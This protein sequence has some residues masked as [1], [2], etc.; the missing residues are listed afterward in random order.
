M[1]EKPK[2]YVFGRPTKYDKSMCETVISKMAEGCCIAEVCA[3]LGI[4]KDTFHEWV[5][6][7]K[8][9]SDSYRIGRDKSEAWW[10]KLGRGGAMGQVPINSPT[11]VFNMKNRFNWRDKQD[12]EHAGEVNIINRNPLAGGSKPTS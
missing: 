3:E 9:F 12:V 8:D 6:E 4:C 7:N 11:W 10:A 5:K 2:G 1:S